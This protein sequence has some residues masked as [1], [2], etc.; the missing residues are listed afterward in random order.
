MGVVDP[1]GIFISVVIKTPEGVEFPLWM[2]GARTAEG[3][4]GES[5]FLDANVQFEDLPIVTGVNIE[6]QMNY[7]ATGTVEVSAT[8]DLGLKLLESE[9]FVIGNTIIIQVGYPRVGLFLSK[10]AGITVKP[11]VT[12]NPGEGLTATLNMRG[13]S[14]AATR[15]T[16]ARVRENISVA[17]FIKE[18]ADLE[19]NRWDVIFPPPQS[20]AG[21]I[22]QIIGGQEAA[23]VDINQLDPLYSTRSRLFQN[24]DDWTVTRSLLRQV[25]CRAVARPDEQGDGRVKIF[26]RRESEVSTIDPVYTLVSRGQI[27]MVSPNGRFPLLSLESEAEGVWLSAGSNGATTADINNETGDPVSAEATPDTVEEDTP[28]AATESVGDGAQ[29]TP[30]ANIALQPPGGRHVSTPD[31]SLE[32]RPQEAVNQVAREEGERGGGIHAT[33]ST[34]G[35]PLAFPGDR[36]RIEGIGIF[37]G[38]YEIEGLSHSVAEGDW[39]TTMKL[40]RRGMLG[41]NSI[42][43]IVR[44]QTD[45]P[46]DQEPPDQPELGEDA[47]SGGAVSVDALDVDSLEGI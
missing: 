18:L 4:G 13:G 47:Q 17:G 29:D 43:S 27:D 10:I 2:G 22:T 21:D 8:Y 3:G 9:I 25:G 1:S 26:V 32:R 40:I 33:V 19:H 16:A 46:S 30:E 28:S 23:A 7:M 12:I 42:A 15:G 31:S 39:T 35:N 11:S 34:I 14:F 5:V 44:R 36:I 24:S 45:N 6:M 37:N 41:D 20:A 38:N